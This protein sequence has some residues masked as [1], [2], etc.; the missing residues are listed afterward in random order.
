MC[1]EC[2]ELDRDK[3]KVSHSNLIRCPKCK[4]QENVSEGDQY[5]LFGDGEHDVTCGECGHEYEISTWVSYT[6]KSPPLLAEEEKAE[7]SEEAEPEVESLKP[8]NS[9]T[10]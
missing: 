1:F 2:S 7:E 6:F 3:D 9:A 10:R 4:H 8:L 5:D